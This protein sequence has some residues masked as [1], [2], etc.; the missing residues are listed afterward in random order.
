MRMTMSSRQGALDE[1]GPSPDNGNNF[2]DYPGPDREGYF[3]LMYLEN[4]AA[5]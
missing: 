1:L 4:A 3:V 2:Y 5:G